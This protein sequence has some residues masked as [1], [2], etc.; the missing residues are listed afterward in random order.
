MPKIDESVLDLV[1]ANPSEWVIRVDGYYGRHGRV[2]G[3]TPRWYFQRGAAGTWY[4]ITDS[5][6]GQ[7]RRTGTS[8]WDLEPATL[9]ETSEPCRVGELVHIS[10]VREDVQMWAAGFRPGFEE[11]DELRESGGKQEDLAGWV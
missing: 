1:E 11:M 5:P 10:C 7:T 2:D 8:R 4:Y 3:E 6:T 9:N